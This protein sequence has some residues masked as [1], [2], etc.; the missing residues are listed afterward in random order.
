MICIDAK[1]P[2]QA[3]EN[4]LQLGQ[5]GFVPIQDEHDAN[6]GI[7]SL[8]KNPERAEASIK[9]LDF[10]RRPIA[11]QMIPFLEGTVGI[12]FLVSSLRH[13]SHYPLWLTLSVGIALM[14]LFAWD[15]PRTW[16]WR[17]EILPE[18]LRVRRR[19]KWKVIPWHEIRSVSSAPSLLRNYESVVLG[20]SS[21][22]TE[23][24]GTFGDA[25]ARS[26]RDRLRFEVSHSKH[27]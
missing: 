6:A 13:S 14:A 11:E 18:E 2:D 5:M 20:L 8:S 4:A 26:L 27:Q 1:S 24:L 17:L 19:Y 16:G 25:F 10:S 22:S 23:L 3:R 9:S 7:L 15:A 12:T 21:N